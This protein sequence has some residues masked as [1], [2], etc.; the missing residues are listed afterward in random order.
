MDGTNASNGADILKLVK[1][2]S[3][4]SFPNDC[5]SGFFISDYPAVV[6]KCS[7]EI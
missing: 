5:L 4:D 6:K 3:E 2:G 1:R 7:V